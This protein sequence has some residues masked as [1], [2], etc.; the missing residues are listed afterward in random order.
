MEVGGGRGEREKRGTE[1]ERELDRD[2]DGLFG[3]HSLSL[4]GLGGGVHSIGRQTRFSDENGFAKILSSPPLFFFIVPSPSQSQGFGLAHLFF[5]FLLLHVV[6]EM[7][8]RKLLLPSSS[9]EALLFLHGR[10]R[11]G[12]SCFFVSSAAPGSSHIRG[13]GTLLSLWCWC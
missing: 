2:V 10:C 3:S 11:Q 9:V 12:R 4:R 1:R 5:I 6:P 7:I 13:G 8:Q